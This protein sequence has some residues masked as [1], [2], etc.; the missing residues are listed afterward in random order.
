M[1]SPGGWWPAAEP[2]RLGRWGRRSRG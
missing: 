1:G 2:L